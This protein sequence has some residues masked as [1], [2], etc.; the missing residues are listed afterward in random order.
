MVS[1]ANKVDDSED[2]H[3]TPSNLVDVYFIR[4]YTQIVFFKENRQETN[5]AGRVIIQIRTRRLPNACW[6]YYYMSCHDELKG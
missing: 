2:N 1:S 6:K 3:S 4:H 5:E